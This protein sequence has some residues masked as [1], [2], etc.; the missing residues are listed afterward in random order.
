MSVTRLAV[1]TFNSHGLL[2]SPEQLKIVED[3]MAEICE[4]IRILNHPLE[5]DNIVVGM[6]G[7]LKAPQPVNSPFCPQTTDVLPKRPNFD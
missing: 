1:W 4:Q 7:R 5:V 2:R 6:R 3:E